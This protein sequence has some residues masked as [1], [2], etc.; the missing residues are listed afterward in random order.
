VSLADGVRLAIGTF[1]IVPVGPPRSVTG[2]EAR[3]AILSAPI[4]GALLGIVATLVLW[5]ADT[6]GGGELLASGLAMATIAVL[7]RGIHLDGLADVADGL[8]SGRDREAALAVMRRPDIGAFGTLTLVF[9]IVLQ[10]AALSRAYQTQIGLAALGLA[11][12]TGRVAIVLA[13]VGGI[14]A[15]RRDGLGAAVAG[16]VPRSA[17]ITWLVGLFALAWRTGN[18]ST[19][20][21]SL[22]ALL[23]AMLVLA[24]CVRRLGGVTGDVLGTVNET[25]TTTAL[26][27]TALGPAS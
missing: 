27:L 25:A 17:A 16:S 7:T 3:I 20:V 5:T 24:H 1:T 15:A 9:V 10:I 23:I 12:V 11:V 4:L 2:R 6:W 8:G 19:A 22:A 18:L 13:C 26:I 14:P 21:S